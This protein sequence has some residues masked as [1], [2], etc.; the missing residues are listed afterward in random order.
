MKDGRI[1]EQGTYQQLLANKGEFQ[2]FLEQYIAEGDE[3][4]EDQG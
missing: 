3:E 1:S 2:N 4:D